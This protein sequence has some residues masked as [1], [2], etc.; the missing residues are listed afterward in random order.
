MFTQDLRNIGR[1]F[2]Y[3]DY[4]HV[5]LYPEFHLVERS[6]SPDEIFYVEKRR[7]LVELQEPEIFNIEILD[8]R[9]NAPM[10]LDINGKTLEG[11]L[12]NVKLSQIKHLHI[13]GPICDYG[14][15]K[16]SSWIFN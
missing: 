5:V 15:I 16:Q 13:L 3:G 14:D 8:Y 2:S 9:Q 6:L 1:N 11:D 10:D 7:E 4:V 12:V